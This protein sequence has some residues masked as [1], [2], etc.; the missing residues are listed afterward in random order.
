MPVGAVPTVT[1]VPRVSTPDPSTENPVT[2]PSNWLATYKNFPSGVT[3]IPAGPGLLGAEG[4]ATG[5]SDPTFVR[6]VS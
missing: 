2:V 3:A 5:T 1:V 4:S 6:V